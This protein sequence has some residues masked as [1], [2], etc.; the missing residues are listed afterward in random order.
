MNRRQINAILRHRG[1]DGLID[2]DLLKAEKAAMRT[3][4]ESPDPFEHLRHIRRMQGW[5]EYMIDKMLKAMRGS[6]N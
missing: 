1:R 2:F 4:E 5:P 3:K 6:G